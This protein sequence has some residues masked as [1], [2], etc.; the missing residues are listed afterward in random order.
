MS[1]SSKDV[2]SLKFLAEADKAAASR[3]YKQVRWTLQSLS[4]LRL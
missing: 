4:K 2:T 1:N 3:Y